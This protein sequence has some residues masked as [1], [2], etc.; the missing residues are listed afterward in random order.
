MTLGSLGYLEK[1]PKTGENTIKEEK[2]NT[3][4]IPLTTSLV[5]LKQEQAT[6]SLEIL[7]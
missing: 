1:L 7:S 6:G 4:G 3:L 5:P 2:S